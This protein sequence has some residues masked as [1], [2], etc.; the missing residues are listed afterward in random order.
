MSTEE[1]QEPQIIINID[2]TVTENEGS[3]YDNDNDDIANDDD[4]K[5]SPMEYAEVICILNFVS[6]LFIVCLVN[7]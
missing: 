6:D 3:E 1:E 7:S 4:E 2:M 5:L